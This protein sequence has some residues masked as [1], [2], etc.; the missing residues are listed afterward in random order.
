MLRTWLVVGTAVS[1]VAVISAQHPVPRT[2][3]P[4]VNDAAT[5]A[6]AQRSSALDAEGRLTD[7]DV[8][9]VVEMKVLEGMGL[10]ED[11]SRPSAPNLPR[12]VKALKQST[13]PAPPA[14]TA[15]L[16]QPSPPPSAVAHASEATT[17]SLAE[18]LWDGSSWKPTISVL[19]APK[20]TVDPK[21][22][23]TLQIQTEAVFTYL[24]PLGNGRF[25]AKQSDVHELGLKFTLQVQPVDG[26]AESVDVAPLEIQVSSL[27]GR[28]SVEGLDLD[29][30]KPIVATRSLKTTARVKLEAPRMIPIPSGPTTQAALLL[31]VTRLTQPEK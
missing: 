28:E 13:A 4:P 6:A 12:G 17:K 1:L 26:D 31:R 29:V 30:G 19:A 14:A 3:L 8:I 2:P 20:V 9:Y 21:Q 10:I 25:E 5:S 22:P 18:D 16:P 27:D 23:A 24:V 15:A 11:A 7:E